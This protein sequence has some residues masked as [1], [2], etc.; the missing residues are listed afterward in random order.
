LD[1]GPL[2]PP[3]ALPYD[4]QWR[5]RVTATWPTG[6][7]SFDA[8]LQKRS[9]ELL[10][11][12]LSPMGLPGFILRLRE[13]GKIEVENRTGRE[14]PFE[15]QYILADV[16]RVFFPWLP[17]PPAAYSGERR[18]QHQQLDIRE[19]YES[20]QLRERSFERQDAPESGAIHIR[21]QPAQQPGEASPKVELDNA[22]FKY[23]LTIET[24]EQTRL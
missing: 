15:P 10:L 16:E 13:T 22:W 3:S 17:P 6:S 12:G 24:L 1:A 21:Y 11:L 14:L 7:R 9:S 19:R 4:F 5:Q 8:V 18:G 23:K 20:G 2:L